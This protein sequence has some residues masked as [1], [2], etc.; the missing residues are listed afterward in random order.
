MRIGP[1]APDISLRNGALGVRTSRRDGAGVSLVLDTRLEAIE[2]GRQE[3]ERYLQPWAIGPRALNR[4]EVV[5]EELVSN[6]V[7]HG[8]DPRLDQSIL[9]TVSADAAHIR[10]V[11][12]DDGA[13]FDP[14]ALAE[15]AT[16]RSLDEAVIGGLGIPVVRRMA[17]R[18]VYE[19]RPQSA[20]WAE[21]VGG[22]GPVNRVAVTL[23]AGA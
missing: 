9:V 20:A 6:V 16:P 5:F 4:L 10:L 22:A 13:P 7:R 15:P 18:T 19:L 17:A 1:G 3:I 23:A 12:E 14:F 8:L 11:V 2:G 21:L